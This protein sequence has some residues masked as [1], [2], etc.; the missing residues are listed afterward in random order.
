MAITFPIDIPTSIGIAHIQFFADNAVS[1]SES[2]FSYATQVYKHPGERWRASVTIPT[3]QRE[4]SEPWVSFL[5]KLRGGE[6]TF[7]MGDPN[8]ADPR[9]TATGGTLTGQEREPTAS[10]TMTG[11]LLEG[12]YI[13]LGSGNTTRLHKVLEDIS[14]SGQ[15]E[16]WPSLRDGYDNATFTTVNTKGLFRLS[17]PT[18]TWTIDSSSQYGIQF[19]AVEVLT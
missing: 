10:V 1:R 2:P 19:D 11:T 17:D 7:L 15:I 9:G 13:Q 5:L 12:D 3:T 6:G 18:S 16:L 4:S 8:C 14:G